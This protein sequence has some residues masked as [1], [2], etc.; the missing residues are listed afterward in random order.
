MD[1]FE[2]GGISGQAQTGKGRLYQVKDRE[3]R[4]EKKLDRMLH[5]AL[6]SKIILPTRIKWF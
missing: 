2:Q 4:H 3:L 6:F 5:D 1:I